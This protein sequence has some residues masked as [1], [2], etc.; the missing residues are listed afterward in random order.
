[1]TDGSLGDTLIGAFLGA[2]LGSVLGYLGSYHLSR[3]AR[4]EDLEARR[5]RLMRA[6]AHEIAVQVPA[7]LAQLPAAIINLYWG[8]ELSSLEPLVDLTADFEDTKLLDA[9]LALKGHCK[10]FNDLI[11]SINALQLGPVSTEGRNWAHTS[12]VATFGR[13]R[14]AADVVSELL[15]VKR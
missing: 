6:L 4:A 11:V 10:V 9:L 13:V 15:Q 8:I 14:R 12:V 3:R 7:E 1:M 5:R 2:G